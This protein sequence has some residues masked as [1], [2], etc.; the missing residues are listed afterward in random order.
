M[1]VFH[2]VTE[3][4]L[5]SRDGC[6]IEDEVSQ[7]FL[8]R[9]PGGLFRYRADD[10]GGTID[11]VSRDVLAMFGC[12]T[13]DEFRAITGNTFLGMVH[14]DDRERVA[15]EIAEQISAGDTDAVAYRLNRPDGE[16][17]WVDDRGRYVVDAAGAAWFYVTI[18]D[19][20]EK[21]SYQQQ[22]ERA[23]DR[24]EILTVLSRD[25]IFDIDCQNQAG[26]VFGDFDARFGRPPSPPISFCASAATRSAPSIWRCT[27]SSPFAR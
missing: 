6:V 22:L 14:P 25:V 2:R 11:Y 1:T 5:G 26:E 18:I 9:I 8:D 12:A 13:Y 21:M 4:K 24:V 3:G 20:T 19:I 15:A 10:E 17:R 16:V 7:E 23:N 27:T